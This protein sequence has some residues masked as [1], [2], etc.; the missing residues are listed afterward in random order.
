MYS[1]FICRVGCYKLSNYNR[2]Q[3]RLFFSPPTLNR[4]PSITR[5]NFTIS[6]KYVFI[7]LVS[8]WVRQWF[9][10]AVSNNPFR[11]CFAFHGDVVN[12]FFHS[13]LIVDELDLKV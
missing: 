11:F 4:I 6:L 8:L 5:H 9:N 10:Y 1:C 13:S 7:I 3:A 12:P 2:R